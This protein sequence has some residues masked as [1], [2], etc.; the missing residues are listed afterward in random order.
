MQLSGG[1]W[2]VSDWSPDDKQM[3]ALEGLSVNEGHLWLVDVAS[4]ERT[5]LA[6]DAGDTVAYGAAKF[7][8]DGKGLYLT[9]DQGSEF[10]RLSYLDLATGKV[11]PLSGDIPWDVESF[12]LSPDGRRVAFLTNEAGVSKL[13]LL[14]TRTRVHQ[15][16]KGVPSGVLG[17]LDWHHNNR[18]LGFTRCRRPYQQRCLFGGRGDRRGDPLD[19]ERAGRAGGERVVRAV[20]D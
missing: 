2:G 6:P 19:R 10:L 5:R 13:H 3:V 14:D 15:L 18:D 1:G 20:S 16:V 8:N 12:A 9:S 11:T 4:G 7:A 17:S